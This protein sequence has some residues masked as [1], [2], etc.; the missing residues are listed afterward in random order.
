[1]NM[2]L[3]LK[4]YLDGKF[5]V[6]TP[7]GRVEC[8]EVGESHSPIA[9]FNNN[10]TKGSAARGGLKSAKIRREAIKWSEGQVAW[11]KKNMDRKTVQQCARGLN[12]AYHRVYDK[13]LVLRREERGARQ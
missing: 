11:L 7:D 5:F 2:E 4:E 1:M 12:I 3:R 10:Y 13:I 8:R 6:L 9:N